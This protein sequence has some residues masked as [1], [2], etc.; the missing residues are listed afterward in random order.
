M[1]TI[2]LG[3]DPRDFLVWREG[4]GGSVEIFD[5]QVGSERGK[6]KGRELVRL[7]REEVGG[8]SMLIWAITRERNKIAI[9]FYGALGFRLVGWLRKFYKDT[10]EDALLYGLDL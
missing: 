6:G 10:N 2:I 3:G 4:S 8:R 5:I 7:L 9:Q 1:K